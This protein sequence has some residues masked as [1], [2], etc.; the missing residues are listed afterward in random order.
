MS[1]EWK[2]F[3]AC[4]DGEEF[5]LNGVNVWACKWERVPNIIAAVRDPHYNQPHDFN[6]YDLVH[7]QGRVRVAAGEF[8][9]CIWGFYL[10]VQA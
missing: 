10:A 2:F 6:V 9:N 1:T 5:K 4:A 3:G 8:S 7:A